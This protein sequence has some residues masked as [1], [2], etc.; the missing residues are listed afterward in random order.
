MRGIVLDTEDRGLEDKVAAF[1][2]LTFLRLGRWDVEK[3]RA[4]YLTRMTR[5]VE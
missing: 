4:A 2:E 1:L 3:V 5:Y